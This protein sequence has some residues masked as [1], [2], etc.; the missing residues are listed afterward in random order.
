LTLIEN[1]A[2]FDLRF[3]TAKLA[4]LMR[5][6]PACMRFHVGVTVLFVVK[7]FSEPNG[8]MGIYTV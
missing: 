6:E 5:Q 7:F 4:H 1:I 2:K 8:P 3:L